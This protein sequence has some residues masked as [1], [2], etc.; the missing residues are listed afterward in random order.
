MGSTRRGPVARGGGRRQRKLPGRRTGEI[1]ERH[2]G[3]AR[4]EIHGRL[5][6]SIP[7]G[8]RRGARWPGEEVA[9]SGERREEVAG[10]GERREEAAGGERAGEKGGARR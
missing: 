8:D 7:C 6:S 3:G 5:A 10:S 2:E 1:F 4:W 9:G